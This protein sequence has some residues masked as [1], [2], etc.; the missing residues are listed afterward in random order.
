MI[1]LFNLNKGRLTSKSNAAFYIDGPNIIRK[2]FN[3]DL[4][5]VRKLAQR[6]GR[7]MEAK[8]F[9]NQH[10]SDKL[11]EAIANQGFEPVVVLGGESDADVDVALAVAVVEAAHNKDIDTIIIGSRDADYLPA[12]QVA[13][14]Y[15]KRVVVMGIEPGFSKALQHVADYV[16]FLNGRNSP[17]RRQHS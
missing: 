2:E 15:N 6:Y 8:V 4:D 1:V 16:E 10:A 7:L 5:E 17:P 9:L 11:I 13:K 12:L 3:L 14:K